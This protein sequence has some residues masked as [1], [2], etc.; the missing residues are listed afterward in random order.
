MRANAATAL[1]KTGTESTLMAAYM[2][3]LAKVYDRD[4]F[5]AGYARQAAALVDQCG[6]KY[7]LRGPVAQCLEGSIG[8]GRSVVISQWPD[9]D[10]A[11][12]FWNSPEYEAIK[13]LREGICDVEV[14]LVEAP[15]IG[16]D[17]HPVLV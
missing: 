14:V 8:D 7:V 13:K 17:E 15:A 1:P 4:R 12:A 5:L 16:V 10:V 11:R 2:I 3:I 9:L 6:G